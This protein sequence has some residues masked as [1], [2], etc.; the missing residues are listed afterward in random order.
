LNIIAANGLLVSFSAFNKLPP[1][2][3]FELRV[4]K[5]YAKKIVKPVLPVE[6]PFS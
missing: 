1:V 2:S 5:L 6:K 3:D 4:K